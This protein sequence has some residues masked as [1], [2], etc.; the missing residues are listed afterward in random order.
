MHDTSKQP[1]ALGSGFVIRDGVVVTSLHVVAHTAGGYAK[2]VG[3][4]KKWDIAGLTSVDATHDL[5]LV[6]V[7]GLSLPSLHLGDAD[8]MAVG[9][10]VYAIGNPEGLEGTFSHGIVSG[11][12]KIG[13]GSLLQITAPISPGSS[14]GPV[15][16]LNGEVIGV[17]AATLASGQSINFA[18]P[19]TFVARMLTTTEPMKPFSEVVTNGR[20]AVSVFDKFGVPSIEGVSG[21]DWAFD[22]LGKYSFSLRNTLDQPI[23]GVRC[24]IVFFGSDG[25][26]I[27]FDDVVCNEVIPPG[28]AKRVSGNV[29]MEVGEAMLRARHFKPPLSPEQKERATLGFPNIPA[30]RPDKVEVRVLDF[31]RAKMD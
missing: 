8:R 13:D 22:I 12:R 6:A 17:A 5:A 30:E 7:P 24:R 29:G 10:E 14:G 31:R 16:N 4:E 20:E 9:D 18:I 15:L 27:H 21:V 25:A 26:P 11:I 3:K 2:A 28:L 1:I 19:S 23:T